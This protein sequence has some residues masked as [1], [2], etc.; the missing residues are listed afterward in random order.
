MFGLRVV[1]ACLHTC[2]LNAALPALLVVKLAYT[3][4]NT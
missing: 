2:A 1:W 3:E 4:N